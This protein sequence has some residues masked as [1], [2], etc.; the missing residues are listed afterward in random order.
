MRDTSTSA[1]QRTMCGTSSGTGGRSVTRLP[2]RT[3]PYTARNCS[4]AARAGMPPLPNFLSGG[5]SSNSAGSGLRAF[6]G[7]RH[8]L[9]AG[10]DVQLRVDR[11]DVVLDRLL[12]DAE[13]GADLAVR[14]PTLDERE[15]LDLARGEP[16]RI[17][18]RPLR[19]G[20]DLGRERRRDDRAALGDRAQRLRELV[21]AEAP[22]HEVAL[23]ARGDGLAHVLG[24]VGPG[25]DDRP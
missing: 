10:R 21:R 5:R 2:R 4:R 17:A 19:L 15:D 24:L 22:V 14:A 20:D 3:G 8:G 1:S 25:D 7:A 11:V 13:L 6:R 12:L 18:R 16:A 9:E 23:R